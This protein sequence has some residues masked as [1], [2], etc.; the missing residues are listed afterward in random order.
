M[1]EEQVHALA[2]EW[3]EAWN[4]HDLD[5]IMSHYADDVVLT[6]P[7]AAELLHEPSGTVRG[8]AALRSYF[9]TG[10]AAFPRLRFE[11]R[12]VMWGLSSVVL[13]YRN[14]RGTMAGELMELAPSGKI[15]RVV[16]HYGGQPARSAGAATPVAPNQ[17]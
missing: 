14:Q 5:R 17:R 6:S 3:M 11:L 12:D 10:L 8:A 2:R 4:A 9:A 13:Y 7:V 15:V 1:T 16:A